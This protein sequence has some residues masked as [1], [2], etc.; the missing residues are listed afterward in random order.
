MPARTGRIVRIVGAIA[1]GGLVLLVAGALLTPDRSPKP[2]E[3][4]GSGAYS[5]D[6]HAPIARAQKRLREVPSDWQTWAGLGQAYLERGR[7]TGDPSFYAKAAGALDRSLAVKPGNAPA[8]TGRGALA[9]ARHDFPAALKYAEQATSAAPFTARGFGVLADANIELGRYDEA[10]AA[11][12]K[13]M[14]LHP[15]ASAYA[16]ASYTFELRGDT[17]AAHDALQQA[18]DAAP[19]PA[20]AAFA[21]YYLGELAF[22]EGHFDE[23][24]ARYDEGRKRDPSYLPLLAGRAKVRAARG[25]TAGALAD[26]KTVTASLPQ[27]A[28]LAEYGDLLAASGDKD[29]AQ[30]Q[31]ALVRAGQQLLNSAGVKTDLELALFDADHGDPKTALT[32]AQAAYA[33]R[34]SIFG[35]DGLA[36]ALHRNG[37]S[38]DALPHAREAVRL[39][40]RSAVLRYHLGAIEAA[41]GQKDAARK[42]LAV[43]LAITPHFSVAEAP[44]A[45]T[46]LAS[47]GAAVPA[48]GSAGGG[49]R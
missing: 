32:S 10:F 22:N 11:V 31:Y 34:K 41:A 1:G 12:Q 21:L 45:R 36:W 33:T 16:R 35:S 13:M 43:A 8:L 39:G 19:E 3:A 40:T 46:L 7:V 29:G 9:A 5:Q 28:Y 30:A 38:A 23:A 47:L 44:K 18:L 15:D 49:V 17:G 6:A 20:D 14:D 2:P 37:R 25:D 48:S 26:Y 4:A 24:A 27:P 42:D